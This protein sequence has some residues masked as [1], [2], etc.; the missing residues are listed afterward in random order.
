MPE[1]PDIEVYL[2]ALRPRIAGRTLAGVRL[3]S[4]FLLRSIDPPLP[5]AHGR[6]VTS[7]K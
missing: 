4:P 5:T 3:N 6:Q 7:R 2:D 1:L